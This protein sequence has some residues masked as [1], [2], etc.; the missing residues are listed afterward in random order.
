MAK[1]KRWGLM[2]SE[3]I[4]LKKNWFKMLDLG[5]EMEYNESGK[6]AHK[7]LRNLAFPSPS[8]AQGLFYSK[9]G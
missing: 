7:P 2:E 5:S 1:R 6:L 8:A 4:W 3:K 9:F